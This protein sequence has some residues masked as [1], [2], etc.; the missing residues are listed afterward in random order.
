MPIQ[1]RHDCIRLR[2]VRQNNLKELDLDLPLGEL[3]V[4]TGVSGSGKSSLAFDTVYAEGQRRYVETFSPY[5]R[6][7]LDRMDRPAADRIDG[8]PPAIAIDQTNPVRTSRSTVA[9]MTELADYLKPL[10][11]QAAR[12]FC[13]GCGREVR[14]DTPESIWGQLTA[15]PDAERPRVLICFQVPVP[16][17]LGAAEVRQLLAQQGYVRLLEGDGPVLGVVQDRLRLTDE[18]RSRALEAIETA[19]DRGHGRLLV[20]PVGEDREPGDPWRFSADLHCP[21]CDIAYRDPQPSLFS[22]NSPVGACE[23]CRGFGR[24]IG[25]DWGLVIPDPSKSLIEGA[26]KPIQSDSYA[27]IQEELMGFA[28]RRGVPTDLPWRDLPQEDRDWVVEGEGEWEDGVWFGIRRFFAWLEGRAYKMHVRVL[29]SRY[30][31]YDVCPTCQG[32]RLKDEALGWRLVGAG[33][34]SPRGGGTPPLLNIQELMALP[35]DRCRDFI[36][37]LALPAALDQALDLVLTEV[38]SRLRYLCEVGLPYLTL[39]RQSRTLSGGEVQ[40][41]NLTTALGTSLVNTL[42]VLDEPSIGLHPRDLDRVVGVL[43]RLRDQGN[44]LLVVEHDPQVMRAADQVIDIGPGPGEHGGQVCFQGTPTELLAAAGSLTGDYLAGRR[45][46]AEPRTPEPVLPETPRLRIR[47]ARTHNLKGLTVEIPLNRLVVVT[48]VSGSGKSSLIGDVLYPAL[49]QLKAHPEETPGAYDGIDGA[50]LIEDVTLLDQ[51]PIGRTSRSNPASFVGA[52]DVLRKRFARLPLAQERGYTAGT[53]SFNAGNGRCPT[54]GGNGF[55]HVEMQFLSDVYLRCPDCDGRRYRP[56]VLEIRLPGLDDGEEL[57]IADVLDL[58]ASEALIQFA[59][60]AELARALAPLTAV[61]L[62]YLRL[63]QAVPTLSGGE[64]QRLKLA[65]HLSKTKSKHG[66]GRLGSGGHGLLFL[67]D[68]PTTGLH[69]ADIAVLIQ[70]LR[71][72]LDQGHSLVV[73]EHNLDLIAAADWLIDLGPEGG[74]QGGALVAVGTPAELAGDNGGHTGRALR[75]YLESQGR[76]DFSP[77]PKPAVGLKSDLHEVGAD[78]VAQAPAGFSWTPQADQSPTR[79]SIEILHAREHNLKDLTVSIPRGQFTVITGVSGSGKSTLAF[80]ILFAEGQRRYLESLNAYARQ[81]VQPAARAD[82]E[83]VHGIP[84]TVA[85]EQRVS[86]G[87][88]KSTVGTQTEIHHFLRLLYVKLGVQHCPGCG[89]AIEPMSRDAIAARILRDH[90]GQRISLM[91]PLVVARKG[92]YTELAEWAARKGWFI[93]RGDGEP[94]ETRAWPRLDRFREHS[95]D[96]PVGEVK[97]GPVAEPELRTLL[98]MA[99]DLGKGLVRAVRVVGGTWGA[100]SPYSTQR[101]CPGCARAYPEPDPRL[102]SYNSK[103]GWCPECLG[104]GLEIPGFDLEQTGAEDQWLEP[105]VDAHHRCPACQGA[106]LNPEALAVSFR[107]RSI[108]EM[109]ALTVTGTARA[110]DGLGLD[111]REDAIAHDLL[112]EVRE[113]LAFLAQVG[114]GYLTLDRGA[115]TLS[116]GEAQRIRLAAQLGSN[117]QGVCYVLDEPSIGLHPRDNRL[118]LDTLDRLRDRGNTVVVV[119]HDEE[120]IRRAEHVIDLG[121]GAGVQGGQVVAQGTAADLIAVPAS[122]TGRFL[123]R[124]RGHGLTDDRPRRPPPGKGDWL[125]IRGADLHNLKAIDVRLPLR[126][127]VCVTGVS[128]SG[129]STLVRDVLVRSLKGLLGE[130]DGAPG[131]ARRGEA[132]TAAVLPGCAGIAGWHGLSR[133]LE[134]DQ[135]P[136]GKTPRSCPA[137]YVGFWD[138]IRKLFA[139][140]AQ[141]RIQGWGAARFSFNTT[142]G[143]CP[144]CEGQGVQRL[145]MSF[146]PDV[147]VTCEQCGGSRFDRE[148]REVRYLGLDIGGVLA[149]DVDRAV[150][151]F[152]AHPAIRHPLALLQEVGLGYLSLGQAS[153]TLSGGEAQRIKL[154]T[155]LAKARPTDDGTH[156]RPTLYVL[157]EPTVGLHMADVERLITVLHRLVDA[158]HTVI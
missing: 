117:L 81:F 116:G 123:A 66:K 132:P 62:G 129:K 142:G 20:Y 75:A 80:D 120:T 14:R 128:G 97:V 156:P 36:E 47:G 157:D 25:I 3:I 13:R 77:T 2:G 64:A 43:Q 6:Q 59:D 148:T 146:L 44:S 29:L 4:V 40:R 104:T 22:F 138:R 127:L 140:T 57:S 16:E 101:A 90:A 63:G 119:E 8:I 27:E 53:F 21:D 139:A 92:I 54:C 111:E 17:T 93:L 131:R 133:V 124:A 107:G 26:I 91:A 56:E 42:F 72:L 98:G 105:G 11:A 137:T 60:D 158:G 106:R 96:L 87:G 69:P 99:L 73:I 41:I 143:R 30:R 1:D 65:G 38:R 118:L 50:D 48:G 28:H 103:H 94:L 141:A 95:I 153:P 115:P 102:F 35:I 135:T 108:A 112:A 136:I 147:R 110:L 150:E 85:I 12:L 7:F 32:A 52:L 19:A 39:D 31:S 89:I 130:R 15:G 83:A 149:L 68:E 154:V 71:R 152:A 122:V 23:T 67:M 86:R 155:E 45:R 145:E 82:V 126:R 125:A 9:T 49:C 134:V 79:H 46:V 144:A 151:V 100:E 78:R 33:A 84:P 10:F 5:A 74:D 114:L 58:T 113:R 76:S 37:R 88:A 51:S 24:T 70:A 18:N 109:S 121:P 34:S 61:G 55:E